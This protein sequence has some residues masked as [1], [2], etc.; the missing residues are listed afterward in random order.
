MISGAF[1]AV[2]AVILES[3]VGWLDSLDAQI[4]LTLGAVMRGMDQHI[5]KH[6]SSVWV[7]ASL[8]GRQVPGPLELF[9]GDLWQY[10]NHVVE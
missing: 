4:N 9:R 6:R 3:V 1:F 7:S 8:P 10:V 5:Q 2:E